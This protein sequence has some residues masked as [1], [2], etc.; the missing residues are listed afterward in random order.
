MIKE[1]DII[2]DFHVH[3]ISSLHAYSSVKENIECAKN[4]GIKYISITDHVYLDGSDLN[5]KNEVNRIK[6]LSQN[7][8]EY[9]KDIIVI[10]GAEFNLGHE[11]LYSKVVTSNEKMIRNPWFYLRK[12]PWRPIGLHSWF[13]DR[14]KL[15]CDDV[16]MLFKESVLNYNAFAHIER[17]LHKI[18]K[19]KHGSVLTPD[20]KN[21]LE[22]IVIL[23]KEN[24][25]YLEVNESSLRNN[26]GGGA[27]RLKYWLSIAKENGNK[28]SMGTDS[29]Y[30][31]GVGLFSL[32]IKML[33][34]V[35][36]Q[37]DLI[38]NC[39]ESMI[40]ELIGEKHE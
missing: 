7:V 14:D 6:Y 37:K 39:N 33:N 22:R 21:L 18:D 25:I 38:L 10:G 34:E 17:E 19:A 1:K 16:F 9:E 26:E 30:C 24:N 23:A 15:T 3:S 2:A 13:V 5:I 8:N 28:I 27:E 35:E 11:V 29:H 36:Y 12:I 4:N 31:M 40:K 32:S 20:I